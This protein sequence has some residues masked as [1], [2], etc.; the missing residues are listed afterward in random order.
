MEPRAVFGE[1]TATTEIYTLYSTSKNP[2]LLQL[3]LCAFVFGLNENKLRV[4]APAVGGCFGSKIFC[5]AEETVCTRAA[6]KVRRPG[7]RTAA[8]SA[9]SYPA[10]QRTRSGHPAESPLH[11]DS[12]RAAR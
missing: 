6:K 8:R 1:D 12:K 7:K 10:D 2:H 5:Y 3:I 9:R 11:Q 4:I